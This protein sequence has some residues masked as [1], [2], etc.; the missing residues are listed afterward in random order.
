ML[1]KRGNP[2][3]QRDIDKIES[4]QRRATRIPTD[5]ERFEYKDKLKRLSLATF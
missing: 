4:V 2:H 1:R 5:F 3:L